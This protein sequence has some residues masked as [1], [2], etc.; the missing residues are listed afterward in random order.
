MYKRWERKEREML[1]IYS[2]VKITQITAINLDMKIL[3][4]VLNFNYKQDAFP[5]EKKKIAE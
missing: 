5:N 2:L 4:I 3:P 1:N